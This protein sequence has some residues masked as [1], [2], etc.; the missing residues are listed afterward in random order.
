MLYKYEALK[1]KVHW[2]VEDWPSRQLVTSR[3]DAVTLIERLDA[4][5]HIG[6][7]GTDAVNPIL[8]HDW[9]TRPTL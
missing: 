8:D 9:T 1:A 3:L 6:R 4:V 5:S 7:L 2:P